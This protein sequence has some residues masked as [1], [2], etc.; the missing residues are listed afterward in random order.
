[1]L[2]FSKSGRSVLP[3]Q[4]F[5][6]RK[7]GVLQVRFTKNSEISVFLSVIRRIVACEQENIADRR[8]KLQ[9]V[10]L[11]GCEIS[12]YQSEIN[13]IPALPHYCGISS[14]KG[15]KAQRE[16]RLSSFS[17]SSSVFLCGFASLRELHFSTTMAQSHNSEPRR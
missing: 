9:N 3:L 17:L 6:Y 10:T 5:L 16:I 15:A 8:C 13:M 2:N 7:E 4:L 12:H 14:R 11:H 1:M